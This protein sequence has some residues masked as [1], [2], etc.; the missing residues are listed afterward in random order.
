[1]YFQ[2][3]NLISS[4]QYIGCSL[5]NG[6]KKIQCIL[7]IVHKGMHGYLDETTLTF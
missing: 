2:C 7:K 6:I 3:T 5:K 1:M 4:K